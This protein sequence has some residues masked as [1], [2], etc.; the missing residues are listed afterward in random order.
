MEHPGRSKFE[1][2]FDADWRVYV[3]SDVRICLLIVFS[4]SR[5]SYGIRWPKLAEDGDTVKS[6][7]VGDLSGGHNRAQQLLLLRGK[8]QSL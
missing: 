8:E 3:V 6:T 7:R 4:I 5:V 1:D 2:N